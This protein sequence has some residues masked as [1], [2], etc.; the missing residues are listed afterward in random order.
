M[1]RI[2]ISGENVGR[3]KDAATM[4]GR[5]HLNAII[6]GRRN[7]I[8]D[9]HRG[10][11][12]VRSV[13]GARC[14]DGGQNSVLSDDIRA[15]KGPARRARQVEGTVWGRILAPPVTRS[16]VLKSG[17][18]V[19]SG[20][21]RSTACEPNGILLVGIDQITPRMFEEARE[22]LTM[23]SRMKTGSPKATVP[24]PAENWALVSPYCEISPGVEG[25][26]GDLAI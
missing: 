22:T 25:T 4:A 18:L 7:G 10:R 8:G 11:S 9:G 15:E 24:M 26:L 3:I 19:P 14:V 2:R 17:T 23:A 21:V 16:P 12:D 13:D 5:T 6:S 20:L 1:E